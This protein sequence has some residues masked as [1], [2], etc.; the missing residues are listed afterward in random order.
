LSNDEHRTNGESERPNDPGFTTKRDVAARMH[1]S[2]KTIN[3][4]MAE[5][6]IPYLKIGSGKQATVLFDW[7]DVKASLKRHYGKGG[8]WN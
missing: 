8:Q 5:G 1:K 4:L 7:E 6:K 3:R 2:E